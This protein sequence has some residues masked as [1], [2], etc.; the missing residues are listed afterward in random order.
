MPNWSHEFGET[1]GGGVRQERKREQIE[2][3]QENVSLCVCIC[4]CVPPLCVC[5][6]VSLLVSP[7][8]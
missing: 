5:S 6:S 1:R 3:E 4:A 7:E 2:R 8:K